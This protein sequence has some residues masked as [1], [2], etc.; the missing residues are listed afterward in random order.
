M[1]VGEAYRNQYTT[2]DA[3][4]AKTANTKP[5]ASCGVPIKT[6]GGKKNCSCCSNKILEARSRIHTRN[7]ARRKRAERLN[8]QITMAKGANTHE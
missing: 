3:R 7:Y 5:C 2:L 6:Q 4:R 1:A 8:Q